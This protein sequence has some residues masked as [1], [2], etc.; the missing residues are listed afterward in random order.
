M[1]PAGDWREAERQVYTEV[2][3]QRLAPLLQSLE[4]AAVEEGLV[5]LVTTH[6]LCLGHREEW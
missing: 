1:C 3:S 6:H 5:G 4:H 2:T